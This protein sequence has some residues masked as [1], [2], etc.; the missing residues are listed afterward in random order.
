ML[1]GFCT[2]GAMTKTHQIT[3]AQTPELTAAGLV[4]CEDGL[5]RPTWA[6]TDSLL[7][8]Y[9]DHEWGKPVTDEHGVFERLCLEGMQAGLSWKT[10]L[11]KREAF[12]DAFCHFDPEK[13]AAFGEAELNA[14]MDNREIL[15]NRRKLTAIITN[16]RATL[17]LRGSEHKNLNTHIWSF[18]P[19]NHTPPASAAAIPTATAESHAMATSLKRLGFT[20]VGPI[21]CYALMQAIGIVNDRIIGASPLQHPH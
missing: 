20:F 14:L 1:W 17:A 13:I 12:R 5:I 8:D 6:A 4:Y 16:A 10:I 11:N 7:K 2:V 18:A 3:T 9:Y 19:T 21:T 15:R